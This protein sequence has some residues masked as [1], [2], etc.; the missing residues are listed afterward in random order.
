[1]P[2]PK[3]MTEEIFS[4]LIISLKTDKIFSDA[5]TWFSAR[6]KEYDLVVNRMIQTPVRHY[7]CCLKLRGYK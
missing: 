6:G 1:M 4:C 2:A 3:S 7:T 5:G